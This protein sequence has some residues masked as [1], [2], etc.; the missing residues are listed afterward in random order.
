MTGIRLKQLRLAGATGSDRT[1]GVSF[2]PRGAPGGFRPLSIITGPSQTGKTTIV[3]FIRY[4]LG[5]G[6]HP[7][8]EEVLS[9][10]RSALL[11]AEL[12]GIPTVIERSAAGGPSKFASVWRSTLDDLDPGAELRVSTEPPSDPSGLSQL[13]LASCHLDGTL[14]ADSRTKE[15]TGTQMLSVR[16]L[17]HVMFVPNERLDNKNLVFEQSNFMVRQKFRQTIDAM[18]GIHD[19][20]EAVLAERYRALRERARMAEVRATTLRQYAEAEY[21]RGPIQLSLDLEEADKS[22]AQ[23]ESQLKA[24][25]QEQRSTAKASSRLR[26]SLVQA[27]DRAK[28]ARVRVRDRRSLISRL[29]SLRAQYSDDFRKLNFLVDAERLFDPLQVVVCP[30]CFSELSIAPSIEAGRCSLCSAEVPVDVV[31]ARAAEDEAVAAGASE[32]MGRRHDLLEAEARAVRSRLSSL[33]EYVARLVAHQEVLLGE[34]ARADAAAQEFAQAVDA[35]ASSP[36]PWLALRDSLSKQVTRARLDRQAAKA[37]VGVWER[38]AQ[39]EA[40]AEDIAEQSRQVNSQRRATGLRPDRAELLRAL[41]TR[42]GEIL[43]EI[44]YPKL[45]DPYIGSD[46]VPHVR[47]QSYTH[48]SSGGLVLIGLAWTLAL[49]EIAHELDA[50]APGLLVIDSPQKNLGH[51]SK[52]GDSDFADVKL[53]EN[54]Y[55]HAKAWLAGAGEGAQLIVVDNSPPESVEADVVIRFTRSAEVPPYGL[56]PEASS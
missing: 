7:Q 5:D 39:A 37:G 15:E 1:Y 10:V 11:E 43:T 12:D 42:F 16:D 35:I 55:R 3:D 18:F 33:N 14:L 21:P 23:I 53:V 28:N 50:D 56:I 49:W 46:L 29:D 4:C 27:E 31:G 38:V 8:H 34:S 6:Q 48:A 47:G 40:L 25:D 19:N 2:M 41:S 20:E 22:L 32:S 26:V 45:H 51:Q 30:A 54:F 9:A 17:F 52:P 44:G 24:L 13:V 36:A